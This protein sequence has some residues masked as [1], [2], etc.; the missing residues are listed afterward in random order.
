[1]DQKGHLCEYCKR[2]LER[3]GTNSL[4]CPGC[5]LVYLQCPKCRDNLQYDALNQHFYCQRC[6]TYN[7]LMGKPTEAGGT[8][9]AGWVL[10]KVTFWV[11]FIGLI[12]VAWY[13]L[14]E[15]NKNDSDFYN[16]FCCISSFVIALIAAGYARMTVKKRAYRKVGPDVLNAVSF[17]FRCPDC[18]IPM[19][20][21]H[22]NDIFKC[23]VCAGKPKDGVKP[24]TIIQE[25]QVSLCSKCRRPLNYIPEHG[26]WYCYGCREYQ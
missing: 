26:R 4:R 16:T 3:N 14:N 25:R 23:K 15:T 19:E 10:G 22:V 17:R 11:I 1:M 2:N 20:A 12:F 13:V 24:S 9:F 8:K 18:G 7:D 6:S 21:D 5:G